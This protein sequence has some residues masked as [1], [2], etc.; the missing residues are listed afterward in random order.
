MSEIVFLV[1]IFIFIILEAIFSCAFSALENCS[2]KEVRKR[3]NEGNEKAKKIEVALKELQRYNSIILAIMTML[4]LAI[5]VFAGVHVGRISAFLKSMHI[6][7]VRF[8]WF[9]VA[10]IIFVFFSGIIL[11]GNAVPRRIGMKNAERKAELLVDFLLQVIWFVKP[12]I[13]ILEG[14]IFLVFKLT[15]RNP[16][17]YKD[18][19]TEDEIIAIVNEGLQQGVL[20]DSEVE[21][22]SNI[23]EMDEKEVR[24][25]MTRRQ[26]I[27]AL[28]GEETIEKSIQKML[29]K[30]FSRFPVYEGDIDNII[31]IVFWKDI[32]KY[33]I[34]NFDQNITL[35]Q[36]AKKPY[37]VP[38]T[39]KIDVLFEE[40]QRKKIHMAIAIDEYGQT[41][42]I[43]AME[44]I[45]EE[46]VGNIFDEFDEDEKMIIRQK[47]GKYYIKGMA[48]LEEVAETLQLHL[49]KELQ[50]Y[51]TLNGFL[52]SKLG[53]IPSFKEKVSIKYQGY[54]FHIVDVRDKTIRYVR[55]KKCEK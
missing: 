22:I 47:D 21:M 53:H 44:D 11:I 1:L 8:V 5:G 12:F 45:L 29:Q 9:L 49:E 23:M 32:T 6:Q 28:N 46:I 2:E 43:V 41:A 26:R 3:I 10:C 20:E 38:D 42:G 31:G 24:D 7:S 27:V 30:S 48:S 54:E 39:Q 14:G 4:N 50:D 15:G 37:F 55:V 33:C 17:E 19:V 51:D 25:I 35:S 36:L 16:E 34:Q 40:M 52:V 13:K 18:N